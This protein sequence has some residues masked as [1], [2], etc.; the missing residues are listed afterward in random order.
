MKV[1]VLLVWLVFANCL[2]FAQTDS[3]YSKTT[4]EMIKKLQYYNVQYEEETHSLKLIDYYQNVNR[5]IPAS[6]QHNLHD[7]LKVLTQYKDYVKK[8]TIIGH[9]SSDSSAKTSEDKYLK[10]LTVSQTRADNVLEYVT[11]LSQRFSTPDKNWINT[12]FNAI[13]R[14]SS[15]VVE[16]EAGEEIRRLSRRVEIDIQLRTSYQD[17]TSKVIPLSF[18]VEKVLAEYPSIQEKYFLVQSLEQELRKTQAAFYPTLDLSYNYT[19]YT[20]SEDDNYDNTQSLDLTLRYNIFNGFYDMK[21]N[22]IDKYNIESNR[23]LKEQLEIDLVKSLIEAYTTIQKQKEILDLAYSNLDNYKTW[24]QKEDIKFQSGLV[25]LNSYAEV[26]SRYTQQKINLEEMKMAYKDSIIK[27]QKY[28]EFDSDDTNYFEVLDPQSDYLENKV[29]AFEDLFKKAPSIKEANSNIAM[30]QAKF[31]QSKSSF[32][33]TVDLVGKTKVTDEEYE[34]GIAAKNNMEE[35]SIALEASFNIFSG[36]ED[37]A[38]YKKTLLEYKQKLQK[39]EEIKKELNYKLRTAYQ[40]LDLGNTKAS[41]ISELVEKRE[42]SYLGARYDYQF[43]K[44]NAEALLDAV[45]DLYSARK[46]QVENRYELQMLKYNILAEIGVLKDHILD[47]KKSS[48]E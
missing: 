36:G 16:N 4:D 33:P 14:S 42:E 37:M 30:Y 47:T 35:T 45:D 48:K 8:V 23:Y 5:K 20:R 39:K 34:K 3:L 29:M 26:Q 27:M 40:K 17:S 11:E 2:A 31:D 9:A 41:L 12:N 13:G 6:L 28:L 22:K 32:Y 24:M 21:Q 15:D 25:T 7:I 1:K 38:N 44:I 18:Y 46:R 10:N 19:D 43:A